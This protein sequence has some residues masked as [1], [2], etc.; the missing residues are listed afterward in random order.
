MNGCGVADGAFSDFRRSVEFLAL[1]KIPLRKQAY[2]GPTEDQAENDDA[3][4][5]TAGE[6]ASY[7]VDPAADALQLAIQNIVLEDRDLADKV[8]APPR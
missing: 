2:I 5:S 4:S 3:E 8:S 7:T 6:K 1:R